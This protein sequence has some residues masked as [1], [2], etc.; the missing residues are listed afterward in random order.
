MALSLSY[1][2]GLEHKKLKQSLVPREMGYTEEGDSAVVWQVSSY[3]F[4]FKII[5]CM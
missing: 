1:Q 2:G 5:V 4:V 3:D